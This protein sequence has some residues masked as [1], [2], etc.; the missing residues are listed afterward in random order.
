MSG[1]PK[2]ILNQGRG[3]T[4]GQLPGQ[5][6]IC[7]LFT[8]LATLPSGF[9]ATDN[10]KEIFG[11]NQAESLGIAKG[12]L[13]TGIL[14]YHINRFFKTSPQ[15]TLWLGI[16]AVP[17][18]PASYDFADVIDFQ[19][20]AG[21]KIRKMGIY[22][23][24]A[25]LTN[26]LITSLNTQ[27]SALFD[28][29][30][31]CTAIF[32]GDIK[33]ISDVNTLPDLNTLTARRV[34]VFIGQDAGNEGISLYLLQPVATRKTVGAIGTVLGLLSKTPLSE[35]IAYRAN[36]NV[37]IDA[38]FDKIGFANGESYLSKN[39]AQL[40]AL[41]N[42][43]Y[44]FFIKD[45][46]GQISGSWISET[47]T[48]TA[49]TDDYNDL[50]RNLVMDE[51]CRAEYLALFPNLNGG[52]LVESNGKLKPETINYYKNI[53]RNVLLDFEE[54]GFIQE[55]IADDVFIDPNQNVIVT[56]KIVIRVFARPI[57]VARKIEVNNS[58]N[59]IAS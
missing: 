8:T 4:G 56:S 26:V 39:T 2:I 12:S 35:S 38:E 23:T 20:K 44:G 24:D 21:G 52:L 45:T 1:I 25:P 37:V 9:T 32:V 18:T 41:A 49:R 47:Y 57:G 27:L 59:V 10:V 13:T 11:I 15:G 16:Y 7:G 5:E 43:N 34:Y 14:W 22:Y 54:K 50:N 51:L 3:N 48:S 28:Q 19:N 46:S 17:S 33:G 42:K 6:H 58:Y 55:V 53:V 30:R 40:D 31:Q 36:S 29:Y